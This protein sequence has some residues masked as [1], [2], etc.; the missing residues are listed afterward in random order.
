MMIE[1]EHEYTPMLAT[2]FGFL[3]RKGKKVNGSAINQAKHDFIIA[4][5][6][7]C[8][9]CGTSLTRN[10]S[11]TEHIHDRA[12]GGHN[13]AG[14]KIIICIDCNLAR[15]KT[16]QEYLGQPSYWKGFPGN[17]DRVK[18]YLL[19]NAVTA[20]KGH[21]AGRVYPEVH[22]IFE[23]IIRSE[24]R[25]ISP[26]Q[27]WFGRDDNLR[28]IYAQNKRR[29]LFVRFF[30]KIFGYHNVEQQSTISQADYRIEIEPT[31]I[32]T[33]PVK[34]RKIVEVD[35]TFRM[36]ILDALD[37][38]DGEVNLA[39]FSSFFKLY[40]TS[41]GFSHKGLKQFARSYGVPKSRTNIQIL[42]DYFPNEIDWRWDGQ[43]TVFIQRKHEVFEV[44]NR[45]EE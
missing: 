45:E 27:H 5:G 1:Y 10:N 6:G 29:G 7:C 37:K 36:H 22:A 9:H 44:P 43:Y 41:Q 18:K 12:L 39:T 40:L 25:K 19:W 17:W 42:Q 14:N 21:R 3:S 26:P 33:Q 15:N 13:K 8:L 16:M 35:E 28:I 23:D 11:N 30:D 24:G 4:N 31:G 34:P 32:E 20:D 38:V 2:A